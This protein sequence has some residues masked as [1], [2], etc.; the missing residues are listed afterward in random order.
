MLEKM[1][2]KE[3]TEIIKTN[4][5]LELD[6]LF[7]S[8]QSHYGFVKEKPEIKEMFLELIADLVKKGELKLANCGKPLEGSI[9]EQIDLFRQ[10]WPDHYDDNEI[11]YDIDTSWWI[12]Y[13]PA[14]AV[15]VWDEGEED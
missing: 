5:G 8:F 11:E 13:A 14:G 1:S 15:W 3:I 10:A 4:K 7:W 2:N 6:A 9:E 12:S